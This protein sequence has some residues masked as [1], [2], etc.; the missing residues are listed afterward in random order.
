MPPAQRRPPAR[1]ACLRDAPLLT[2][3]FIQSSRPAPLGVWM[4]FLRGIC[5]ISS[6][7]LMDLISSQQ[8]WC[9]TE[10]KSCTVNKKSWLKLSVCLTC[11]KMRHLNVLKIIDFCVFWYTFTAYET[12]YSLKLWL[13]IVLFYD[14]TKTINI[15]SLDVLFTVWQNYS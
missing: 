10:R 4:L 14:T 9:W 15:I 6:G 2:Q 1:P 7:L 12:L 11:L 8:L 3:W 5:W 13:Q